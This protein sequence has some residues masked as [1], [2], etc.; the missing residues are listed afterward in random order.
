MVKRI[1]ANSALNAAAGLALLLIGFVCSI[2]TARLLGPEANGIIAFSLW[3]AVTAAL[4]SELGTGVILL[5]LLPQLKVQGHDDA[6]RR[7]FAA[8]L[9]RPVVLATVVVTILYFLAFWVAEHEHWAQTA[10]LV[11][12]LTGIL[13]FVQSIGSFTKNVMLGEQDVAAFFRMSVIAGILQ[14]AGVLAGA[15]VF[16]IPGAICGY[17]L[18]FVPQFFYSLGIL[19]SRTNACGIAPRYLVSSSLILSVQYIIDSIFLNRVELFF[20]ERSH[21]VEMVGYYAAALSLANL[22]LQ[23]PVQLTGSLVPYYSEKLK[24]HDTDR[25]P[26]AVFESVVRS[27]GYITLPL[28]F[29]LAAIAPTLVTV[30]FGEAFAPSGPMLVILALVAPVFVLCMICTQ[31]LFSLDRIKDRLMI[32]VLGAVIM[33]TGSLLV[34]PSFG[35]EGAAAVRFFVFLIMAVLMMRGMQFEGSL[36]RMYRTVGRVAAA[37]LLCGLAAYAVLHLIGGVLGLIVSI[38]CGALV[39]FVAL[40]LLAAIPVEDHAPIEDLIARLPARAA[41]AGDRLLRYLLVKP[42]SFEGDS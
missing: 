14:F 16:G 10:P 24:L 1:V 31:Y 23:L 15:L 21:G 29:G 4:I 22:A 26:V 20:L 9:L 7:G 19:K 5:R 17:V 30:V 41:A 34:V 39:Y 12:L 33:V 2:I 3:L 6:A 13:I 11:V 40:R 18:G 36:S 8:Y 25:L 28:S 27:I 35:G 32:G 42:A 38:A 37:A